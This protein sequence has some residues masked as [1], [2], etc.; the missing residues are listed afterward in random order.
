M[1]ADLSE[2]CHSPNQSFP[3]VVQDNP[4]AIKY[5]GTKQTCR[6]IEMAL[7]EG[8]TDADVAGD[9]KGIPEVSE[10]SVNSL[11]LIKIVC[12]THVRGVPKIVQLF[13]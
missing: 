13:I 5:K 8:V 1:S 7:F 6:L 11:R 3:Y 9:Q 4:S 2:T 12:S 10:S